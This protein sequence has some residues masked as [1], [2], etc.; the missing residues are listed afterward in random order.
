MLLFE[1]RANGWLDRLYPWIGDRRNG[2]FP[3]IGFHLLPSRS[4]CV[5]YPSHPGFQY[6]KK[7]DLIGKLA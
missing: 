2:S 6:E 5:V 7:E 3:A 4:G 1:R